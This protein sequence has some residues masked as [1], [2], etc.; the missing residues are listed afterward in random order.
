VSSPCR[1]SSE[2]SVCC[3][4]WW[5]LS[6]G[7]LCSP[8]QR[9]SRRLWARRRPS[10]LP[11]HRASTTSGATHTPGSKDSFQENLRGSSSGLTG[12]KLTPK[13]TPEAL[14][15]K[16]PA[17]QSITGAHFFIVVGA[18]GF[19]PATSCS[20]SRSIQTLDPTTIYSASVFSRRQPPCFLLR[21]SVGPLS[22]HF[23]QNSTTIT[24]TVVEL[25]LPPHRVAEGH[26][27]KASVEKEKSRREAGVSFS[28]RQECAQ[29]ARKSDASEVWSL[30]TTAGVVSS[31]FR[32]FER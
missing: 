20:R 30:G 5:S 11:R 29:Q 23:G 21:I 16:T 24:R 15:Q 8:W 10:S 3:R 7:S 26:C 19:E 32:G 27:W 25:Q 12:E 18:T 13:I 28:I 4:R 22:V 14:Q 6:A 9:R 2:P 31:L 17:M 1:A